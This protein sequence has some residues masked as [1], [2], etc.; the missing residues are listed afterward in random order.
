[1]Y[2]AKT[3]MAWL[4]RAALSGRVCSGAVWLR[5][6]PLVAAL[7]LLVIASRA[8]GQCPNGA[9][10][11]CAGAPRAAAAPLANS[12]AVLYFDSRDSADTFLA[13]GLSEEIATSL[14]HVSRLVVK[15]PS[16]VRRVQRA[17]EGDIRAIG[18]ALAVRWVVDGSVRRNGDQLRISV[19]LGD[20]ERETGAWSSAVSPSTTNPL[21]LPPRIADE[22]ATGIVGA[23]TPA[24]RATVNA[25]PTTNAAA[26]EHYLKGNWY[27]G[28]RGQWLA[29]AVEEYQAA[30]KLDP[31]FDAPRAGIALA[32]VSAIDYAAPAPLVADEARDRVIALADSVIQRNPSIAMAWIARGVALGGRTKSRFGIARENL[33][34]AVALEPSSAEAHFRLGQVFFRLG[35]YATA[36]VSLL[37]SLAL[38]PARPVTYELLGVVEYF[39]RRPPDALRM[40]DS[41]LSLDPQYA[42]AM[43]WKVVVLYSTGATANARA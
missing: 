37:R 18:R 25:R 43:S 36:R 27:L 7:F 32:T 21:T 3:T 2:D 20:A 34:R 31:T 39:E 22:Q 1:M 24:E 42:L 8:R 29:R 10:P 41:A 28:R 17:N 14:G 9:P 33:E 4:A 30:A 26:Y 6:R 16:A 12:V 23:L 35:D 38:D 15:I 5:V 19:R 11:P 13:E 40:L